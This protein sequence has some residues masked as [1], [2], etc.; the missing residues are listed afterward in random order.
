MSSLRHPGVLFKKHLKLLLASLVLSAPCITAL[1][2][3]WGHGREQRVELHGSC[4]SDSDCKHG[5]NCVSWFGD[6]AS[7]GCN[8]GEFRTC[9]IRCRYAL[10]CPPAMECELLAHGHDFTCQERRLPPDTR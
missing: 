2:V 4:S 8:P 3:K 9:E 10:D 5:L 7:G 6:G 1:F